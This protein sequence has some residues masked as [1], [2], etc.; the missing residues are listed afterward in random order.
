M[1]AASPFRLQPARLGEEEERAQSLRIIVYRPSVPGS[2]FVLCHN[3]IVDVGHLDGV[4]RCAFSCQPEEEV[5]GGGAIGLYGR[6]RQAAFFAQPIF[7]Y[8]DLGL[9]RMM[10]FF[11]FIEPAQ[12]AQPVDAVADEPFEGLGRGCPVAS[13][14]FRPRPDR[15]RRLD[16]MNADPV[17][18]LQV[19]TP[20]KVELIVGAFAQDASRG[21]EFLEMA[22]I[23]RPRFGK[24]RRSIH[25][26]GLGKEDF[27]K[28]TC[29]SM[30]VEAQASAT[31]AVTIVILWRLPP[32]APLLLIG[33]RGAATV[34]FEGRRG[35]VLHGPRRIGED[36]PGP[37]SVTPSRSFPGA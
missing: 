37:P 34:L 11:G 7:E 31:D 10:V 19:Q 22:K 28:H 23:P 27:F 1:P 8:P 25:L 3:G 5:V 29:A 36:G 33:G 4:Q 24:R 15:R 13:A 16:P 12:K 14:P 9:M 18:F 26:C 32:S 30:L 2:P 6:F 35:C 20:N 17:A 21:A